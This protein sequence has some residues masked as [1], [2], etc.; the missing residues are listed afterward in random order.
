MKIG[1]L[2]DTHDN[3]PMTLKA[4]ETFKAEGVERLLHCGDL[5]SESIIALFEGW[6]VTFADGNMDLNTPSLDAAAR[7]IGM[8]PLRT[9]F[10]L[11]LDGFSVALTHGHMNL[12]GLINAQTY[13]YVLHGH[14]HARRD[15]TIGKTRVINPGALGGRK[16]QTRSVAV[17][18]LATDQLTFIEFD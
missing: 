9:L 5:T 1:I 4:L 12:S 7:A 3:V 15:T 2:S 16:M 10:N 18:D 17:L 6:Q 11:T 13:R 8:Q 14:T